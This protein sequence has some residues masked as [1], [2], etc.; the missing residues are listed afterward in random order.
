MPK[1][2]KGFTMIELL[3][4]M[5]IIAALATIFISTFPNSQKKARD[6]QRRSDLKQY[7]TA[8]ELYANKSTTGSYPPGSGVNPQ[9]LCSTLGLPACPPDPKSGSAC[10]GG[11]CGYRYTRGTDT[12]SYSLSALLESPIN[13]ATPLLIV[14]SNGVT[15]EAATSP[16]VSPGNPCP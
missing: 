8:L 6:A 4:V 1:I 3:I 13:T 15:K 16:A 7:Q 2:Q 11:T 10:T 14:C 12:V 5:A 9:T